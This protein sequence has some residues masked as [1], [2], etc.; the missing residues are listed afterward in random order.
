MVADE[1]RRQADVF[2]DLV[3]LKSKFGRDPAAR[4]PPRGPRHMP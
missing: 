2:I 1:L 3:D 4:P